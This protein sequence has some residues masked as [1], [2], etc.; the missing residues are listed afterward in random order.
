MCSLYR[1]KEHIV[2]PREVGGHTIRPIRRRMSEHPHPRRQKW[3]PRFVVTRR[4]RHTSSPHADVHPRAARTHTH[5]PVAKRCLARTRRLRRPHGAP[6][7]ARLAPPRGRR[8][9]SKRRKPPRM[10][11][12]AAFARARCSHRAAARA[13]RGR[14]RTPR[15]LGLRRSRPRSRTSLEGSLWSCSIARTGRM[16]G[17]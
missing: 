8:A 3:D 11:A 16:R 6:R 10:G 9:P 15:R 17:I 14:T 1:H 4:R 2:L 12:A 13:A 7:G 5:T